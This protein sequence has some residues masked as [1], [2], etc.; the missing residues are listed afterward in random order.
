[1]SRFNQDQL[2]QLVG[3]PV[4]LKTAEGEE[5][6]LTVKGAGECPLNGEEWESFYVD[7]QSDGSFVLAQGTY[8]ISHD[9]FG[10]LDLFISPKSETNYEIIV[11]RKRK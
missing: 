8:T 5:V 3:Q 10:S 11:N 4:S 2:S 7:L 9:T 6:S 1:M